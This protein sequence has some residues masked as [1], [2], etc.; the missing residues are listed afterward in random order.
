MPILDCMACSGEVKASMV[1]NIDMVKPMP[2]RNPRPRM[3]CQVIPRE[4]LPSP[5][6]SVIHTAKT[7]PAGL[8]S[9]KPAQ[10]PMAT[11]LESTAPKSKSTNE[12]PALAR[13]KMGITTNETKGCKPCSSL[14]RGGMALDESACTRA[15]ISTCSGS[16]VHTSL[17][18]AFSNCRVSFLMRAMKAASGIR[19]SAGITIAAKTAEMVA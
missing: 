13:A 6:R 4:R 3:R 11:P 17:G 8:P 16:R 10:T 18:A 5:N 7:M 14:C 15:S 1:T 19:A 12:T 2:A 9:S